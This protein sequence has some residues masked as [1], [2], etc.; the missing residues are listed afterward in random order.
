[1]N[2]VEIVDDYAALIVYLLIERRGV[3]RGFSVGMEREINER[4]IDDD[5]LI[6]RVSASGIGKA[7]SRHRDLF[8]SLFVFSSRRY[9]PRTLY[10]FAGFRD[11]VSERDVERI[12]LAVERKF[13]R[14]YT[15]VVS[16]LRIAKAIDAAP[17][18]L[19][20]GGNR[21]SC[22]ARRESPIAVCGGKCCFPRRGA[23]CREARVPGAVQAC[24]WAAKPKS[25][26]VTQKGKPRS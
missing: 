23:S 17:A 9:G 4:V 21:K 11:G 26:I 12:R 6:R 20:K 3:F 16:P 24:A 2:V 19:L 7:I 8:R 14:A 18:T 15:R 22:R 13:I 10:E 5:S 1:M 25:G